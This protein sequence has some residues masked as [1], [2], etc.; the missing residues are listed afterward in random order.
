MPGGLLNTHDP[1]FLANL[2]SETLGQQWAEDQVN[3]I[4][5]AASSVDLNSIPGARQHMFL[6]HL[7]EGTGTVGARMIL[8]S[9]TG[10]EYAYTRSINGAA[11]VQ[12]PDTEFMTTTEI[13]NG[14]IFE[15]GALGDVVATQKLIYV[16]AQDSQG[17]T[18]TTVPRRV[19]IMGKADILNVNLTSIG[20]SNVD[21]G[22]QTFGASSNVSSCSIR[23]KP[24]NQPAFWQT[25]RMARADSVTDLLTVNNLPNRRYLWIQI[26]S[27]NSGVIQPQLRLN[28][29]SGTNYSDRN[30]SNF[31]IDSQNTSDTKLDLFDPGLQNNMYTNLWIANFSTSVKQIIGFTNDIDGGTT[32]S[33]TPNIYEFNGKWANTDDAISRVDLVNAGIGNF[34][35]GTTFTIWGSRI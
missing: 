11:D 14:D 16:H 17:T 26:I 3:T 4:G 34:Q 28:N 21:T 9:Q 2:S 31:F 30:R 6:M 5:S 23:Q 10:A 32:T 25:L 35:V 33:D 15:V 20:V 12:A 1:P 18:A 24:I 27:R 22:T 8:I 19:E 7:L 13:S 29:D